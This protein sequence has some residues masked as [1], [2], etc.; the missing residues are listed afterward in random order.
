M[1]TFMDTHRAQAAEPGPAELV[2]MA[3]LAREFFLEG[4]SKVELATE[5]GLSRYKIARL[6]N[7]ARDIGLVEVKIRLPER[8]DADLSH[9]LRARF[10]L[11]RAIVVDTPQSS[12]VSLR[13]AFAPVVADLLTELIEPDDVVGIP[14]SRVLTLAARLVKSLAQCTI[15]QASGAVVHSDVDETAVELVRRLAGVSGSRFI[16]YYGP[17]VAP[18]AETARSMRASAAAAAVAAMASLTKVF[19]SVGS[20]ESGLSTVYDSID[21]KEAA[22]LHELG[23]VGECAGL[24]FDRDGAPITALDD[25]VIGMSFDQLKRTPERVVIVYGAEKL[26]AAR[27][28]VRGGLATIM[29]TDDALGRLL[30]AEAAHCR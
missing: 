4:K 9:Q 29:V 22:V 13:E 1:T 15:V 24:L 18:T 6:L 28:V 16:N 7:A 20:W 25:R 17:I 10:N 23:A 19:V 3:S 8:L 30:L 27:A 26:E 14:W 2:L 11:R 5:Y 12:Q 21:P